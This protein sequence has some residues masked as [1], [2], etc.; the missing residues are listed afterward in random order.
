[1]RSPVAAE[2][3]GSVHSHAAIRPSSSVEVLVKITSVPVRMAAG[4]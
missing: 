4:E 1:M 3:S 2:P